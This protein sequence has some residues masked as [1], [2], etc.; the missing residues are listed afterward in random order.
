MQSMFR[1]AILASA[2]G[3]ATTLA[4]NTAIAA[5]RGLYVPF[6]FMVAGRTFP[7]GSYHVTHDSTGS[8]VTLQSLDSS[9][10]FT[11]LLTPGQPSWDDAKVALRFDDRDDTHVLKSIQFGSEITPRLDRINKGDSE[12]GSQRQ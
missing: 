1:K 2:V 6:D 9:Q 3:F 11:W 8:F 4:A 10:S 12:Q 5:T 7:A